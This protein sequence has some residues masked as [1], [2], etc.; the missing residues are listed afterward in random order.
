MW[1]QGIIGRCRL[2]LYCR[3]A[4]CIAGSEGAAWPEPPEVIRAGI[5]A[6]VKA[7]SGGALS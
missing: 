2:V 6:R 5:M 4:L 3:K 1:S 7:A